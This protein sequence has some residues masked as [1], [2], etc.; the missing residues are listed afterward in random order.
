M[1]KR[2]LKK[3]KFKVTVKE[4]SLSNKEKRKLLWQC[5]D[6]LLSNKSKKKVIKK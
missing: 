5:F 2:K 3:E 1:V 4:S 6:I